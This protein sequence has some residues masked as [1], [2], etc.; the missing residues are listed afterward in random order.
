MRSRGPQLSA[1]A[2]IK[3]MNSKAKGSKLDKK[4]RDILKNLVEEA[5]DVMEI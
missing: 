1:S 3:V 5:K 2:F 4:T